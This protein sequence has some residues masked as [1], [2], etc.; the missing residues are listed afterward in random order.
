M[1]LV[2]SEF[3]SCKD[4][5]LLMTRILQKI[6]HSTSQVYLFLIDLPWISRPLSEAMNQGI[7]CSVK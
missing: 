1:S 5:Y 3:N 7:N 4:R 2:E 6:K